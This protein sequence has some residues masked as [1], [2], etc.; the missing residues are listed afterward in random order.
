MI[1]FE[2]GVTADWA[3]QQVRERLA[4]VELPEATQYRSSGPEFVPD[5]SATGEI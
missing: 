4:D 1:V 2:D 3:R 5:T